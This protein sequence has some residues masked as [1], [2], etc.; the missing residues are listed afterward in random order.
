MN[1]LHPAFTPGSFLLSWWGLPLPCGERLGRFLASRRSSRASLSA[2]GEGR[3]PNS[4]T[5]PYARSFQERSV[6]SEVC[7]RSIQGFADIRSD[8]F[9]AESAQLRLAE[10][11]LLDQTVRSRAFGNEIHHVKGKLFSPSVARPWP[12]GMIFSVAE[13]RSRPTPLYRGG[14]GAGWWG[15]GPTI[16]SLRE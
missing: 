1:C 6:S 9:C 8:F 15:F 12:R 5:A 3:R 16:R 7:A 2:H 13:G 10:A 14:Q 11:C 4:A